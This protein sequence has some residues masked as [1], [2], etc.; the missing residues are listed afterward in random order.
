MNALL[1]A[2]FLRP[3]CSALG[4]TGVLLTVGCSRDNSAPAPS[5]INSTTVSDAAAADLIAAPPISASHWASGSLANVPA[6]QL[7]S[8]VP[9]ERG[10]AMPGVSLGGNSFVKSNNPESFGPNSAGANNNGWLTQHA[11]THAGNGTAGDPARGGNNTWLSGNFQIY[12]S[13][14]NKTGGS[15]YLQV[16]LVNP[17]S[18]ALTVSYRGAVTGSADTGF[19]LGGGVTGRSNYYVTSERLL[20]LPTTMTSVTIPAGGAVALLAKQMNN[21]GSVDGTMYVNTGS[22]LPSSGVYAYVV[23]TNTNSLN[24]AVSLAHTP[25]TRRAATGNIEKPTA[26]AFGKEAGVYA[27]SKVTADVP[28]PLPTS[29]GAHNLGIWVNF[30]GYTATPDQPSIQTAPPQTNGSGQSLRLTDSGLRT[31]C[32]YNHEYN[33]T[34]RL[35]NPSSTPRRVR[36]W[37]AAVRKS[38]RSLSFNSAMQFNNRGIFQVLTTDTSLKR[39]LTVVSPTNNA[40]APITV[41]ANGTLTVPARFF[42]AGL[43]SAGSQFMFETVD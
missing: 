8:I 19:N 42:V 40:S 21:G 39:E 34:F 16:I 11:Y 5:V 31:A 29:L 2:R 30:A 24:E 26:S 35:N 1:T 33:I 37:F 4:L 36:I 38:G 15:R 14:Y 18:S 6:D 17:Q 12:V 41:P 20:T 25:G 32:N 27:F 7:A 13:H 3:A 10:R 9:I 23:A 28:V 22:S 43:S